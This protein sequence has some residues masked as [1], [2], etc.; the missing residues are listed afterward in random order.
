MKTQ[1]L[2]K[3]NLTLFVLL[4]FSSISFSQTIFADEKA[5]Y[6]GVKRL[7]VKGSFCDV[8]I[9]GGEINEVQFEGIIKGSYKKER[10][11]QFIIN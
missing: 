6:D 4:L 7:E 1:N 5:I 8:E 9:I 10:N 11:L 3:R 2:I